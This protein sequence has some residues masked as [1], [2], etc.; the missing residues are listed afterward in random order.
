MKGFA[1]CT[2]GVAALALVSGPAAA[3]EDI[4]GGVERHRAAFAGAT[5]RL[6]LGGR[7]AKAPEA[8]L[9]IGFSAYQR[10]A[11]G[12]VTSR[13]GPILPIEAGLRQGR[14]TLFV[15]GERFSGL[16]RRLGAAGSTKTVLLVVGGLALAAGAAILLLDKDEEDGPCPPGVEVCI[17]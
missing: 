15:G 10:D 8:R 3:A 4:S 11:A 17:Q 16:E 1:L 12:F 14:V 9:G 6:E 7:A 5:L 13:G 2:A